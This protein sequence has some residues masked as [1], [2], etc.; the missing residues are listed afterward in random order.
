MLAAKV[1]PYLTKATK[2]KTLTL[3]RRPYLWHIKIEAQDRR[4]VKITVTS[5]TA[6]NYVDTKVEGNDD[7]KVSVGGRVEKDA[8]G[9]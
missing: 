7:R 6:F 1:P 4:T 8:E 5:W 9:D 3:E 2:E